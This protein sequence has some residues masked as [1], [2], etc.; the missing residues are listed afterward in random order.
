MATL[1]LREILLFENDW[2]PVMNF[3]R[4]L[5]ELSDHHRA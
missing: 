2:H 1:P 5:V 3:S 4:Q